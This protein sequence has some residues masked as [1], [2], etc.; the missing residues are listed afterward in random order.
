LNW[1]GELQLAAECSRSY[2]V[3]REVD[4]EYQGLR[5]NIEDEIVPTHEDYAPSYFGMTGNSLKSIA[6]T[7]ICIYGFGTNDMQHW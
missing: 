5:L 4:R 6:V 7:W 3:S 2:I 1:F